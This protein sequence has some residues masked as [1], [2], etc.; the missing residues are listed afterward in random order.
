MPQLQQ[1]SL[2][3]GIVVWAWRLPRRCP[4]SDAEVTRA[5]RG[6]LT[7]HCIP[8]IGS[9]A[10]DRPTPAPTSAGPYEHGGRDQHFLFGDTN[11]RAEQRYGDPISARAR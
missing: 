5:V 7:R 3:C 9:V 10:P 2:L 11:A 1:L 4:R 8:T 6:T